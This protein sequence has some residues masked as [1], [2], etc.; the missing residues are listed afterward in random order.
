MEVMSMSATLYRCGVVEP[1]ALP[2]AKY[3]WQYLRLQ[4]GTGE[5]ATSDE[6]VGQ[7]GQDGWEL[8]GSAPNDNFVHL[9]FKRQV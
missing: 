4:V 7:L 1:A 8:A 9:W 5:I 2:G 6:L 3:R